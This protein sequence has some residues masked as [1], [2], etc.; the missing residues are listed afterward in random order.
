[1]IYSV[2][3]LVC[4]VLGVLELFWGFAKNWVLDKVWQGR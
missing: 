2:V 1:M 3:C 4:L